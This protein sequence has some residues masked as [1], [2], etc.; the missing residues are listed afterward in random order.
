MADKIYNV[1]FLCTS[2]SARSILA[3]AI[4]QRVGKGRFR[5]FSAGSQP[6]GKVNPFTIEL[7]EKYHLPV[8]E[9][10]S[11]SWNE[12]AASGAPQLDFIVTV[13]DKAAGEACPIWPGQPLTTH[14]SVPD[15][16]AVSG[17]DDEKR[18]AFF[19]AY[20]DLS[21]RIDLLIALPISKLDQLSLK[22]RL[23]GIGKDA[24]S[25]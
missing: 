8:A 7:L 12:F 21:H 10:R 3:E 18:R 23:D 2:N 16:A 1:L 24:A 13:C 15:P 20:I 9:L 22:Q 25:A 17:S 14:W 19:H 4:L 6:S 5:A 11:K